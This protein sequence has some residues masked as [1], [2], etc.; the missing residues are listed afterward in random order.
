MSKVL[1]ET[2]EVGMGSSQKRTTGLRVAHGC[3]RRY[4]PNGARI[5]KTHGLLTPV[6]VP[7]RFE[8]RLP[9]YPIV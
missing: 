1:D 6:K 3:P 9:V 7:P 4:M 2:R 8:L 5:G